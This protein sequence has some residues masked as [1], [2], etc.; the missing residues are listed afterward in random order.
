MAMFR[1]I[2]KQ[3]NSAVITIPLYLLEQQGVEIGD[4]FKLD[5]YPNQMLTLTPVT[6]GQ[7]EAVQKSGR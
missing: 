3:G 4:Y 6:K 1:R 5:S 2:F 7:R